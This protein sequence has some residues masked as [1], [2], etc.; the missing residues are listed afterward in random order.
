MGKISEATIKHFKD[1][2]KKR[3]PAA[4]GERSLSRLLEKLHLLQRGKLTRAAVL[5][6]GKDPHKFIS[7]AHFQI[8]RF[9][10]DTGLQSTDRIEGNL[11]KQAEES[12]E[13]L[14]NKYLVFNARIEGL[15]RK[16]ELEYPE[17]A[18]REAILNAVI[19]KDYLGSHIQLRVHQDKLVFGI[20]GNCLQS[21][22]LPD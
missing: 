15:Y 11:F 19:H 20:P 17:E 22:L 21:Y 12:L 16:E 2:A 8:G 3:F 14:K 13:I 1:L 18:L 9:I 7:G 4:S 6:F 10:S 5:L